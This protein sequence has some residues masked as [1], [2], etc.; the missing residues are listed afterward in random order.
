MCR[1]KASPFILAFV[2]V[3]VGDCSLIQCGGFCIS[4]VRA[5]VAANAHRNRKHAE[6]VGAGGGGGSGCGPKNRNF[7]PNMIFF[8]SRE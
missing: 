8:H 2:C 7:D 4:L 5:C 1:V 6:K 3:N